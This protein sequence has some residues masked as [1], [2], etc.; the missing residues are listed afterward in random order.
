MRTP[1]GIYQPGEF[2]PEAIVG[3]DQVTTNYFRVVVLDSTKALWLEPEESRTFRTP[4][5]FWRFWEQRFPPLFPPRT[6]VALASEASADFVGRFEEGG[7]DVLMVGGPHALYPFLQQA[8]DL[9]IPSPFQMA[10]ALASLAYHRA[11]AVNFIKEAATAVR[12]ARLHLRG[13][14]DTLEELLA[15]FQPSDDEDTWESF[16]SI[17]PQPAPAEGEQDDPS[18]I[19]F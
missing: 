12:Q 18:L 17:S 14:E 15:V 19:E 1:P 2:A 13:A 11:F 8:R 6:L 10:H 16:F 3:L 4:L 7:A 5:R 9:E